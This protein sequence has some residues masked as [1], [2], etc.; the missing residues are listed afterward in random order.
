VVPATTTRRPSAAPSPSQHRLGELLLVWKGYG[1]NS[2]LD[3]V[4]KPDRR[5]SDGFQTL[6]GGLVSDEE[7]YRIMFY[8]PALR[9]RSSLPLLDQSRRRNYS[10]IDKN[11]EARVCV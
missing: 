10:R 3:S 6:L 9:R 11:F 4:R 1:D 8:R 2:A 5:T 7:K